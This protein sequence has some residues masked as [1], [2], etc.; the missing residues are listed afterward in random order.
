M[1]WDKVRKASGAGDRGRVE[2]G[3]QVD[4]ECC[5][6]NAGKLVN[7]SL[8][9]EGETAKVFHCLQGKRQTKTEV[10]EGLELGYQ[11]L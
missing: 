1:T 5:A 4:F 6:L 8:T 2:D 10:W 11:V 7:S 3:G 9:Q